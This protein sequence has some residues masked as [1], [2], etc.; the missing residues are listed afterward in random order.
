MTLNAVFLATILALVATLAAPAPTSDQKERSIYDEEHKKADLPGPGDM[1]GSPKDKDVVYYITNRLRM[2]GDKANTGKHA[3]LY[4]SK[5]GGQTWRLLCHQFEF[6]NLFVHPDTERLFAIICY[7]WLETDVKD[8]YLQRGSSNKV[9]ASTDG[10][11]WK[12]ITGGQGYI[13]GLISIFKDPD[14]PGRV[15]L[16]GCGIR[17]YV[18]QAKDEK[19][20]DWNWLRADRPEGERLLS[21]RLPP[22][23]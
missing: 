1:I 8:G 9:I 20:T 5:D 22:K 10:R 3:G 11:H 23:K 4:I 7:E 12:D 18:F 15:C 6:E 14:N 17:E 13:S 2:W 21:K 19:Y 16:C